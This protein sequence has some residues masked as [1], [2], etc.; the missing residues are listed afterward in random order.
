M[1][2]IEIVSGTVEI[3]AHTSGRHHEGIQI[4]RKSVQIELKK[5]TYDQDT[6]HVERVKSG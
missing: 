3:I 1:R 4:L 2:K 5:S 6:Q